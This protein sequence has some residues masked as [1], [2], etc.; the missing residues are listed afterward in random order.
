MSVVYNMPPDTREKEKIVGG[1]LDLRQFA[2]I[3]AG[4]I[5]YVIHAFLLFKY[6][7]F[8]CLITGLVFLV[9]GLIFGLKKKDNM[10]YPTYLRYKFRFKRRPRYFVNA[11]FHDEF[12]FDNEE[13]YD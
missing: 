1:I 6:I 10:P 3:A 5:L 12:S 11:G 2:W 4:F 9:W 8:V 7:N 13:L